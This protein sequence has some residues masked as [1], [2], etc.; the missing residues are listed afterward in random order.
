MTFA[1][2]MLA[3]GQLSGRWMWGARRPR[4]WGYVVSPAGQEVPHGAPEDMDA[5]G[6]V[7][8]KRRPTAG[9][10]SRDCSGGAGRG[11]G[12]HRS[13]RGG[14]LPALRGRAQRRPA[15]GR[16]SPGPAT[17]RSPGTRQLT[18]PG[19]RD[20]SSPGGRARD[21]GLDVDRHLH[22]TPPGYAAGARH[23]AQGVPVGAVCPLPVPAWR[24]EVSSRSAGPVHPARPQSPRVPTLQAREKQAGKV[25]LRSCPREAQ[26]TRPG[27]APVAEAV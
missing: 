9:G 23:A 25:V 16:A 26:M 10:R 4:G 22:G 12:Q 20:G 17:E 27:Q 13:R 19:S 8:V 1:S 15:R 14:D 11:G 5:G 2:I 3:P 6:R 24:R 7:H 21:G 18:V